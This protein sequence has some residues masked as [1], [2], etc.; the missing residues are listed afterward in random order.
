MTRH[1]IRQ[2]E[3]DEVLEILI[4]RAPLPKGYKDHRLTNH[5]KW[6][7]CR[8]L[9]IRENWLL[10]YYCEDDSLNLVAMGTHGDLE[11]VK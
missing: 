1:N 5:K 10:V 4:N 3:L 9:H 11:I 6:N 8:E 7:G 2:R